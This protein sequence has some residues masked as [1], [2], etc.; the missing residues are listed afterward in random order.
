MHDMSPQNTPCALT[1]GFL[2]LL[3]MDINIIVCLR[4]HV[5]TVTMLES[6]V[7]DEISSIHYTHT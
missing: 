7:P 2:K 3:D 4:D 5:K 6:E 1:Y